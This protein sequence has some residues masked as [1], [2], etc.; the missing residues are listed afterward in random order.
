MP[1]EISV[2]VLNVPD[3]TN[4]ETS[5]TIPCPYCGQSFEL[6]LNSPYKDQRVQKLQMRAGQPQAIRLEPFEVLVFEAKPD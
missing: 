5:E 1:V 3:V 4:M 2:I 6:A